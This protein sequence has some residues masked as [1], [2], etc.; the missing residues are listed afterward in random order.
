MDCIFSYKAVQNREFKIGS[1][2]LWNYLDTK[3]ED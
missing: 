3:Y 2:K 1:E